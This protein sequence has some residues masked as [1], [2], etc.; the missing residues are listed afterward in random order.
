MPHVPCQMPKS[1]L[2]LQ[3]Q[4]EPDCTAS[5]TLESV[6]P[7][8]QRRT[9]ESSSTLLW[10]CVS[11]SVSESCPTNVLWEVETHLLLLSVQLLL[12]KEHEQTALSKMP[13]QTR[14]ELFPAREQLEQLRQQVEEPQE[15]G[16]VSLTSQVTE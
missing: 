5:V 9:Q 4:L 10:E 7:H 14:G 6:P 15:N 12:E 13:C 1:L 3:S 11:P 8:G 2:E 16:Q